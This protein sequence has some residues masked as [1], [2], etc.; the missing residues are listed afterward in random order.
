MYIYTH[1]LKIYVI[2]EVTIFHIFYLHTAR[3]CYHQSYKYYLIH[4]RYDHQ[5][6]HCYHQH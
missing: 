2:L 5:N 6:Y 4:H 3:N 1:I